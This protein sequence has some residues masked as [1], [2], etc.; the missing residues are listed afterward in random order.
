MPGLGGRL[1]E[2][3]EDFV[4][5]EIPLYEPAGRGDHVLFLAEKRGISTFEALLWLSKAVKVSEHAIGYA[6]LKDARAVTRQWMSVARVPLERVRAVRDGRVR[7]LEAAR[8]PSKVRIGHL[9]GNRFTVRI[10]GADLSRLA[11]AR[12]ALGLLARRGV[13]NAYGAQRFG[14][15]ED[16]HLAGRA[17]L[18]GDHAG[19]LDRL[20]GRP[21]PREGDP[22]VR[23]ARAAYDAGDRAEAFRLF[24]MKHRIQK[25]ALGAL[26]RTGD[27]AQAF[28][29]LGKRARRIYVSA[30]QSWVFNR[31]LDARVQAGT[32][33]ELL[34]GDLAW[35]HASG[36]LVPVR[37]PALDRERAARLEASPSGP[38]PGHG[39]RLPE[40]EP[41]A[42]EQQILDEEA[43]PE[44]DF[45]GG[46][47]RARGARRPL[48]VP[49]VDASLEP[50]G[51]DAVVAR[52]T[53]PPG[54]FATVV[55]D[56]VMK[57]E[58]PPTDLEDEEPGDDADGPETDVG[59]GP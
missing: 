10:R 5:E 25:K 45:L 41:L 27:A 55:L 37:D 39:L 42:V 49:L 54:S 34:A 29:A 20:L 3:P 51:Q 7:V 19:F 22:R 36:A 56:E 21:D 48:R 50:E 58:A 26:I 12:R 8:H 18:R 11:D 15:R 6:G 35:L 46:P 59:T 53:L 32:Y 13:P 16:G 9:A 31:V 52:F 17:L 23:A 24:P 14:I 28:E 30:W 33:D 47:V 43:V 1:R 4:V 2:E 44:A 38:L 40:G 57:A